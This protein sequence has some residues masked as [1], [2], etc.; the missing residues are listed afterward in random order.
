MDRIN[1]CIEE[2]ERDYE[3]E[4]LHQD[5]WKYCDIMDE[6]LNLKKKN[7]DLEN[8]WNLLKQRNDEMEMMLRIM[9]QKYQDADLENQHY[10][11]NN[12]EL[13]LVN[14]HLQEKLDNCEL[15]LRDEMLQNIENDQLIQRI[16]FD[17]DL[18][19]ALRS[20]E[21]DSQVDHLMMNN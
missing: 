4:L 3:M 20:D 10:R 14:E 12:D 9:T 19:E 6:N 13:K 21:E 16:L 8:E 18:L 17:Q 2:V 15:Q 7:E 1:K 11:K 5:Q